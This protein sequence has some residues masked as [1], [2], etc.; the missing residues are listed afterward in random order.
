[1]SWNAGTLEGM[2][3]DDVYALKCSQQTGRSKEISLICV[4]PRSGFSTRLCE[5]Q[6]SPAGSNFG[7]L[8]RQG[9]LRVSSYWVWEDADFCGSPVVIQHLT[10][11]KLLAA[12]STLWY[13]LP[14]HAAASL[15][16]CSLGG[17][18]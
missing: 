2:L 15:L 7:I 3:I 11:S 8:R 4:N 5:Y 12:L 17:N 6:T 16:H 14:A 13:L 9:C 10:P 1:M 18:T